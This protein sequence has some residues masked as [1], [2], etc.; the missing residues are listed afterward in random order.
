MGR[1]I[2]KNNGKTTVFVT[3][4]NF[5]SLPTSPNTY[6]L[7]VDFSSG[8][9]EKLNPSGSIINLESGSSTFTGGTVTGTTTFTNG[10]SANTMSATTFYGDGSNLTGIN[11]TQVTRIIMK[12]GDTADMIAFG[13]AYGN[14]LKSGK[15]SKVDCRKLLNG[16][17]YLNFD[18]KTEKIIKN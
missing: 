17:Y 15:A 10:L 12:S 14:I 1:I 3:G 5:N 18:N 9:F 16:L 8:Y 11:A 13:D 2:Q 6:Y 4:E 7:G